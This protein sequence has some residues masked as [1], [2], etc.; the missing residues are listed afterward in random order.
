MSSRRQRAGFQEP[1]SQP[2]R[3]PG[4]HSSRAEPPPTRGARPQP[5]PA[6]RLPAGARTLGP[7]L[8]AAAAPSA[9][10]RAPPVHH[11]HVVGRYPRSAAQAPRG[12]RR[13]RPVRG[14]LAAQ[15]AQHH[16]QPPHLASRPRSPLRPPGTAQT[17]TDRRRAGAEATLPGRPSPAHSPAPAPAHSP[18]P[19]PPTAPT[20]TLALPSSA[21]QKA[22]V[23]Q[24]PP[25]LVSNQIT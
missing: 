22:R 19:A 11:H 25:S 17:L 5:A 16:L 21:K 4:G 2:T 18:A 12:L 3:R 7:H 8:E 24:V 20:P 9:D 23:P 14:G 15:V 6:R 10:G 13:R 1:R